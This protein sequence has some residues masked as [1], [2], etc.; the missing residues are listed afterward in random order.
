MTVPLGDGPKFW[1]VQARDNAGAVSGFT[2]AFTYTIDTGPPTLPTILGPTT[3]TNSATPLFDWT[4][5]TDG[6]TGLLNYDIDIATDGLFTVIVQSGSPAA[7]NFTPSPLATNTYFWRIRARDNA[8][9]VTAYQNASFDIDTTAPSVPGLLAPADGT[10]SLTNDPV[11]SWSAAADVGCGIQDYDLQVASDAGFTTIVDSQ[12]TPVTSAMVGPLPGGVFFWRVRSRD[13]AGN[14]SAY[15][16]AFT[17]IVD[18]TAP[19]PGTVNDGAGPDSDAQVSTTTLSA[20]W[21]GFTDLTALTYEWAIGTSPGLQDIQSITPVGA[22]TNATNS[23]LSL[24]VGLTYYVSVWATDVPG[25]SSQAISD[26][27]TI[28][29]NNPPNAPTALVQKK[30]DGV[31]IIPI[32]GTTTETAFIVEASA[33]DVEADQIR[34][35]VEVVPFGSPFTG[36]PTDA[37]LYGLSGATMSVTI[38]V[39]TGLFNWQV[40]S[41]DLPGG[42]S[43]WVTPGGSPDLD[44]SPAPPSGAPAPCGEAARSRLHLFQATLKSIADIDMRKD[45]NTAKERIMLEGS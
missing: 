1:R 16:A 35:Q 10:A 26:G 20:N 28:V 25:N 44:V 43:A 6:G 13:L 11:L 32:G 24:T 12:T 29:P 4:D 8:G 18:G 33:T 15:S 9:N 39:P 23:S 31:T 5:S 21:S 38:T 19:T 42:V 36:V 22:S 40:R 17:Y 27:I 2:A 45:P 7:S 14:L 37:G 30:L 34:L 3:C 41:E